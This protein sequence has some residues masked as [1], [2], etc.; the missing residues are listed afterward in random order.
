MVSTL[1]RASFANKFTP[2]QG[3]AELLYP[4]WCVPLCDGKV[5]VW[6]R[7]CCC[8]HPY[9][10]VGDLLDRLRDL[11]E[12]VPIDFDWPVPPE[13]EPWGPFD[14]IGRVALN[15][16]PLPPVDGPARSSPDF[17]VTPRNAQFMA[18]KAQFDPG[19][20]YVS[21]RIYEDYKALVAMP[22]A[23]VRPISR[24][25]PISMPISATAR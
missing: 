2:V 6:E 21:D 15:P 24:L 7:R 11:L 9:I 8:H 14:R 17:P 13:P 12:E 19:K 4:R 23:G 22:R 10:D 16:Q 1:S 3:F 25:G 5:E 18:R 20:T